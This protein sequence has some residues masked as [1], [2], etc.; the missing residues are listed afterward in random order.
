[1]TDLTSKY[2]PGW[3]TDRIWN[4]KDKCWEYHTIH[5]PKSDT[6]PALCKIP[7]HQPSII[8]FVHGVNSEGEWYEKAERGL[9]AGLSAAEP[10]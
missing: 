3:S 6:L 9:V 7:P 2:P 1:M 4:K 8:L 5:T 10:L